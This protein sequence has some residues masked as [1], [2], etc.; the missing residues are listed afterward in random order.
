MPKAIKLVLQYNNDTVTINRHRA[1][2]LHITIVFL[3]YN[4]V[5]ITKDV[6]KKFGHYFNGVNFK[7]TFGYFC[8]KNALSVKSI[9]DN[10][11][12][13]DKIRT[14]IA[15]YVMSTYPGAIETKNYKL[16]LSPQHISIYGDELLLAQAF[17]VDKKDVNGLCID[18]NYILL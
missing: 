7:L 10:G 1:Q 2:A 13:L 18:V 14:E 4:E 3:K 8:S 17:N 16:G 6:I 5:V 9:S 11:I 12:D 15:N